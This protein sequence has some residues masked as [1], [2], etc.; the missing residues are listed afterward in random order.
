MLL[1]ILWAD[2]IIICP[3]QDMEQMLDIFRGFTTS[4]HLPA[5]ERTGLDTAA[6]AR[7]A[8]TLALS[9]SHRWGLLREKGR[10][11]GGRATSN[12]LLCKQMRTQRSLFT[13][14]RGSRAAWVGKEG[15]PG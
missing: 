6:G 3:K 9:A 2:I 1:S 12:T 4:R 13:Q 15:D 10:G 8:C 14:T 5:L 7:R 11:P